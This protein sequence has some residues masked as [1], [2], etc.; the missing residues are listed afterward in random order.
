MS[1]IRSNEL[2][3]LL[4]LVVVVAA[5]T[6][7]TYFRQQSTLNELEEQI[8]E[9]QEERAEIESLYEQLTTSEQQFQEAAWQWQ[10]RYKSFPDT[11][12][13]PEIVGYL[14]NLTQIGF[15]QFDVASS[16][17][18]D[19]EGYSVHTFQAVGTAPFYQLYRFLWRIENNR[20]FYQVRD[21]SIQNIDRRTTDEETGR[22]QMEILVSFNMEIDGF[23]G[24]EEIETEIPQ[25]VA[26]EEEALPVA[27]DPLRPSLPASVL[28]REDPRLNP[29]YPL[30]LEE[31]P[32]NEEGRL[33]FEATPLVAIVDNRAIFETEEGT[34]A[35]REGER[36][37]LGRIV[38]VDPE[39]GRVLARL[40]KGGI[41]DTIE[42]TLEG[43]TPRE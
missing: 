25:T 16:G 30:I 35:V 36:V 18:E 20:P 39:N 9:K 4:C 40:N 6:Y 29:F 41:I 28:P 34:T 38:E 33:N 43:E 21:L 32:P 8:S 12:S 37:Y 5:G 15:D 3:L 7:L 11:L 31:V 22:T 10:S 19:Q 26:S 2:I 42:R 23:Y 1:S 27:Q 24:G 14:T 13:S 17:T